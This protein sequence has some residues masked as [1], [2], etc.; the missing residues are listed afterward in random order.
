MWPRVELA[1]QQRAQRVLHRAIAVGIL[2]SLLTAVWMM[3]LAH[4]IG[5][6]FTSDD[7][8][9]ANVIALVGLLAL[10]ALLAW[11]SERAA[12]SAGIIFVADS[13]RDV[14]RLI[15][16]RGPAAVTAGGVGE[17]ATTLSMGVDGLDAYVARF[18]PALAR[19]AV[20][21]VIV[22][23][24]VAWIDPW[25]TLVLLFTGPMLILLLAVIGGRT[26]T[27]GAR[28]MEELD[29]LGALHLDMIR[30]LPT[31]RAFGRAEDAADS[32]EGAS[33][34]FGETTMEVLRTAFQTS[35]VIEWA[36]TVAT[37][38]VA[39]EVS[40]RMV[41]GHLDFTTALVVLVLTPEFFVP[42]RQ[43]ATEYHAGQSGAA[44]LARIVGLRD[45]LAPLPAILDTDR[46]GEPE[47]PAT[48]LPV[49]NPPARDRPAPDARVPD[50]V[51]P[52]IV[53]DEVTFRYRPDRDPV[54]DRFDLTVSPGETVALV[55]ASGA[56]KST[57]L[58]VVMGFL[59]PEHGTVTIDGRNLTEVGS[60]RWRERIAWIGQSPTLFAG[61]LAENLRL[62]APDAT[63]EQIQAALAASGFGE[64]LSRL[65]DGLETTVGELGLRLSGGERQRVAI[66]RALLRDAPI[67]VLDEFTAGLD[68]GTEAE[69]IE[70]VRPL[71]AH[72][73]ALMGAHRPATL[74][75]ADRIVGLDASR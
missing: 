27:L 43:L 75:L 14:L 59:D 2:S 24:I 20:V 73:T 17:L 58:G 5:T 63:D 16:D 9:T 35:L 11:Y 19:A 62:A 23:L 57:V 69:L 39:V 56:G 13:R 21:P 28:R 70:T 68:R 33:R 74:D 29:R 67:V 49:R 48:N 12:A 34:R 50:P 72:R 15:I 22:L 42:I 1:R 25:T 7:A 36:G 6:A 46:V 53:V 66:A 3:V 45:G 71:L 47:P 4:A 40:F 65:P 10:R 61:T 51:A 8:I 38:L 44:T 54:L 37:A 30:G 60:D 26:R 64:V 41:G 32:L 52:T 18:L 55:G 31:L